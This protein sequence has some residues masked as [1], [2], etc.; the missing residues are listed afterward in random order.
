MSGSIEAEELILNSHSPSGDWPFAYGRTTRENPWESILPDYCRGPDII[1]ADGVLHAGTPAW[2]PRR[3]AD[4]REIY[5]NM[6]HFSSMGMTPFSA[7]V[8]AEW[9]VLPL[10]TDAAAHVAYRKV[11]NPAFTPKAVARLDE[12][13]RRDARAHVAKFRDAG[14]CDFM[15]E[16]A[17]EFPIR[18]F[19]SLMAMPEELVEQFLDW[20][21]D[22]VH[23]PDLPTLTSATRAVVDYLTATI[24]ERKRRPGE[25][26]ISQAISARTTDERALSDDELLGVCFNLFIGGLDSVSTNMAWQ[27]FHL[28]THADDQDTLRRD[29]ASIPAAID[30]MQ[31]YYAA[32]TTYRRCIRPYS[33]AGATIQPGEFVAMSTTIAGRDDHEFDNPHEVRLRRRPRHVAFGFGPHLCLG[34]HLARREMR[35]ALEEFLSTIP[36]FHLREGVPIA[37]T[38]HSTL[39]PDVLPIAWDPKAE[40]IS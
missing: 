39:Q 37:T 26:L 38:L 16:F 29:M 12:R 27:I 25:H 30:E 31:R 28:A 10:E 6:Q 3:M 2:V 18:V 9:A 40:A 20:E 34:V 22:L 32:V 8:D 33:V 21:H 4:I 11:L 24:D 36:R 23:S 5:A 7:L 15:A 35:I 14:E 17:L 19:L 13:M 1:Y